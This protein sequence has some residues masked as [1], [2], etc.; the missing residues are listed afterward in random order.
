[1]N[2]KIVIKG[3]KVNNLKNVNLEIP[4]DKL[5]VLTGLSGS[6][7]SSLAFDTLY[8]EGQ[9]RYVESLSSYARQFLGQMDKPNVEYIEGLS[10]AISIDQKTTSKNPRSTVGTITEIYDYLRLLYA[11]VGIPH[12][13]KC[14]KEITK[15]SVDQIV[16]KIMGYGD[17]SKLQVLSPVVKGRKGTHEKILE[18]IKKSGFVR[19]RIDGEIYDLTEE[20]VKLDKNKKHNIEAVIDRIVIK[21]GIEGRLTESVE[22]SLKMGEGLVIISV[23]GGEETLFSENFA[24]PDCGISI[25]ELS[26]RLFSFN[27]PYGKCDH[28]DGLGSLMEIDEKLVIPNREL[29]V[30]EGA[31]ASWGSGRLKEDS[32][33]YAILQALTKEYG[34][35]LSKPIKDLDK[36]QVDLLFYG[37]GGKKL[38]IEYVKDGVK[39][40]YSYAFEGEIN[41]L[42]RRYRESNS[43]LIKGEIEQY[44]SNDSCPK[45]KGARLKKEVLAV[46]VG[47]KNI[48]EFTSMSIKEELE[49]ING[50]EFSE[51]NKLISEQIIKEIKNRL[52]FL[53]DV[54]LDY[55]SLSR[56][57][58]TL[59]GGESQRIRLATQI[60]SA[61]MG[62]LYILDEPSIGLHQRDNDRL[63]HTLK[64]LRDVGNTV[65]VVEH[66]EDT[67]KEA[68]YIVDIGPGAGEHGGEVVVAG[69]LDEVKACEKSITGQY[70]T[71]RKSIQIPAARRK[72]NGQKIKIVGAKENN[73][74]NINV[75]IPLG[76]LTMVTGVSG[77]GKS[78]LVNEILYKG[79]NRLVNK[80]KNPVGNHKE[81][82]GYENIDKI[83]DINQS[84][85]GRTPRSNPATYTGTFDIIR[86]L[87]S[88]TTEAKMRGYK[89][90]RFSFNVKG[91]RCEACSG[92]GIIKIEMQFL[93]DVYVP[94][95]VCKGKRYNRETLEVK[96]K[97]KNIDDVLK[98]T[99]EEALKFFENIPRIENKLRTLN[100]VGLGYIRLGQPSTQLS[101][102][103]AQRIKLAYE[104]SK[105]STGKTLYI[106]DEPT[107][108]LHVDDVSRLIEILQSLVETG[109]TVVVIEHNLDMIKCAD[110][111][112]DLGPEGGDKGGTIIKCGTPE[113]L[114]KVQESYTGKYL[115]DVLK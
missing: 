42:S 13:P 92:D 109:N 57:S 26:P 71:G 15:Q 80:S 22:A 65:V 27:A 3:A 84:P 112:I 111:L 51:K 88:Q 67:M 40:I 6:G 103:E 28:C 87:F 23:I 14:G 46:T 89:Q 113:E 75:S 70:L 11:R 39:A 8:A 29:S 2:D 77:S 104:L 72:G 44:M 110:Y 66:D 36:E 49:F 1:M 52:Q 115:K 47:G 58:G 4:R 101:G 34:L 100:D 114:C 21:E 90:G 78:T 31:I 95:E 55:L 68:D 32:W 60:G 86:E 54:G 82:V 43:D 76:T 33:T 91:G 94:C 12:C 63:I 107:T 79:L 99:V 16:D 38:K 5:V 98:M 96:Y 97:G 85:I 69:T 37:T 81:I 102:G 10:P 18:H 108:G 56:N 45:C 50:V 62:V 24:C 41:A 64:N 7:K 19:A 35:D 61:L 93:S 73:L 105:R 25:D 20:E 48:Y 106:L 30:M 17:R 9:R 59:S 74:K 53:L 83:I